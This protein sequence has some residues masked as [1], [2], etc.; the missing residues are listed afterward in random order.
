MHTTQQH[1]FFVQINEK[2]S[3]KISIQLSLDKQFLCGTISFFLNNVEYQLDWMLLF[4]PNS[5]FFLA[6]DQDAI[7]TLSQNN[8]DELNEKKIISEIL[9]HCGNYT[10]QFSLTEWFK[11]L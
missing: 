11:E 8:L 1:S 4:N 10:Q 9:R 7:F 5:K 3:K 2:E 6:F